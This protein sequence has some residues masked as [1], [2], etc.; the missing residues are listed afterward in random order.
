MEGDRSRLVRPPPS[1]ADEER[2][3]GAAEEFVAK[4]D[5]EARAAGEAEAAFR[6]EAAK[7]IAELERTRAFAFRR[8]NVI[9]EVAAAMRPHE[10]ETAAVAAGLA[11]LCGRFGWPDHADGSHAPV[12]E[13][14]RPVAAALHD[15][16]EP[17]P[18][19]AAFE[20]WFEQR[21]G[22]SFWALLDQ[23]A[24]DSPLVDF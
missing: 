21:A 4:L 18:A 6:R 9:K 23:P 2:V 1:C 8:C 7:R 14:F 13:A 17:G 24:A 10:E 5:A 22:R 12:L 3:L 19:L 16:R 20:S 11:S 15:G